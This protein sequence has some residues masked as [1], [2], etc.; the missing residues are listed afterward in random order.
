MTGTSS[1]NPFGPAQGPGNRYE[2]NTPA[3]LH[4]R[5]R[6]IDAFRYAMA[7]LVIGIHILPPVAVGPDRPLGLPGWAVVVDVICRCAV[8]F[9][10][11]TS[12][13]YFRPERGAFA[14]LKRSVVRIA[15]IYVVWYLFFI[16]AAVFVPGKLPGHWRIMTLVDGGPAFHL[17]FLPALIFGLATLTL[18][19]A[20]GGRTL[21]IAVAALLAIG[22]PFLANYHS[23]VGMPH[24]SSHLNDFKRQLAAPAFVLMGYLFRGTRPTNLSIA[25]V[26]C[27]VAISAMF[28]ERYF[29][30]MVVGNKAIGNAESLLAVFAYGAAVFNLARCLN[31]SPAVQTLSWLGNASL[32]IYLIHVLFIWM[33]RQTVDT[34]PWQFIFLGTIVASI[35]TVAA[36]LAIRAPLLRRFMT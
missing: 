26:L 18:T 23:L 32:G 20:L 30:I 3:T 12:G 31:N 24:Y 2:M 35:S 15:P 6:G 19:L 4:L 34:G 9:F 10:F 21:A 16:S 5:D 22:G 27:A 14:N 29:V 1:S 11:I 17:W 8:P 25:A 28:V 7:L 13:Y 36:V 33:F